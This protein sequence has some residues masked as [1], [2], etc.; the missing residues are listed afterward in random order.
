MLL[1]FPLLSL[2]NQITFASPSHLFS[3]PRSPLSCPFMFV[4]VCISRKFEQNA[5]MLRFPP[6]P[7]PCLSQLFPLSSLS[8]PQQG[9]STRLHRHPSALIP[10]LHSTAGNKVGME[11]QQ[12]STLPEHPCHNGPH[13]LPASFALPDPGTLVLLFGSF[14]LAN[15]FC[16][17]TEKQLYL[18]LQT[19]QSLTTN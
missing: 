18:I 17:K 16:S 7:P 4:C 3:L 14:W 13:F 1:Y 9:S 2:L 12:L 6:P 19:A 8:L 5:G 10:N 15:S 11:L